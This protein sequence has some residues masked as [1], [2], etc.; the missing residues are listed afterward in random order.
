[1]HTVW[2][3]GTNAALAER[4]F[5]FLSSYISGRATSLDQ[6]VGVV[7]LASVFAWFEPAMSHR[8]IVNQSCSGHER[9]A[10][11]FHVPV[12]CGLNLTHG[13]AEPSGPETPFTST[14]SRLRTSMPSRG[15]P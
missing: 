15:N 11:A 14:K 13:W 8:W 12:D 3:A 7:L 10:R 9:P 5:D 2:G 6:P 4:L 1:M